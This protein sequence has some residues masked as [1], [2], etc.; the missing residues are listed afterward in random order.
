MGME[1]HYKSASTVIRDGLYFAQ[2]THFVP[3]PHSWTLCDLL[4]RHSGS[5]RH[6]P[7]HKCQNSDK[8]HLN[9]NQ[10]THHTGALQC[11][12]NLKTH[13]YNDFILS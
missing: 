8:V 6:Q 12:A 11:T 2:D 4:Y 1:V 3:L 9:T 10:L 5:Y 13:T 7:S